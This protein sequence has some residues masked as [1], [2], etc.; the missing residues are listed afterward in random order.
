MWWTLKIALG[1]R[2]H[3]IKDRSFQNKR[4][5]ITINNVS[6]KN[7]KFPA[8]AIVKYLEGHFIHMKTN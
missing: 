5:N 7:N 3:T 1:P 4:N 6:N 8:I 2:G